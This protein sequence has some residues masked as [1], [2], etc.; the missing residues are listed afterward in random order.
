MGGK[1]LAKKR[2]ADKTAMASSQGGSRRATAGSERTLR[3]RRNKRAAS[4]DADEIVSEEERN[5]SSDDQESDENFYVSH[6][7]AYAAEADSNDDEEEEG[8]EDE[9]ENLDEDVRAPAGVIMTKAHVVTIAQYIDWNTLEEYNDPILNEIVSM[10]KQ[11][12]IYDLMGYKHD[13]NTE[14]IAQF[15]ATL[16]FGDAGCD[17]VMYWR[18]EGCLYSVTYTKFAETFGYGKADARRPKIHRKSSMPA[19][20]LKFMYPKDHTGDYGKVKGLYSY[21]STLNRMFR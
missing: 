20:E 11:R 12:K 4:K 5:E 1:E 21:Y 15:F 18:T 7:D 3:P 2:K 10:C 14:I 6:R 9:E 8:I 19:S 16:Y 17:R 13:W